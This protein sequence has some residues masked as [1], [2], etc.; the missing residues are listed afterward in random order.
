[1]SEEASPVLELAI[2]YD[3]KHS[4]L[5][6]S[7]VAVRQFQALVGSREAGSSPGSV[8]SPY[9]RLQ[10]LL[11]DGRRLKAK[12]HVVSRAAESAQFGETFAFRDL[13]A[14][15]PGARLHAA[16]LGFDRFSRDAVLGEV[17]VSLDDNRFLSTLVD[18]RGVLETFE[19]NIEPTPAPQSPLTKVNTAIQPLSD[20]TA[21]RSSK[22]AVRPTAGD[23]G[24]TWSHCTSAGLTVRLAKLKP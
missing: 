17:T 12:T 8:A 21:R 2:A 10:L 5:I 7:V 9:V 14:A 6:V 13:S 3:T 23:L 24:V 1:M 19:L 4:T 15:L 11:R 18:R 22:S 20:F 16:V